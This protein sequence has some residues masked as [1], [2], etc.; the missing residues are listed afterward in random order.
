VLSGWP[1]GG[2]AGEAPTLRRWG[3]HLLARLGQLLGCSWCGNSKRT[4]FI[5]CDSPIDLLEQRADELVGIDHGGSQRQSVRC[6]VHRKKLS[7]RTLQSPCPC[8]LPSP[9]PA[10]A[11]VTRARADKG[12]ETVKAGKGA[13]RT[14]CHRAS[15]AARERSNEWHVLPRSRARLRA[16]AGRSRHPSGVPLQQQPRAG[17]ELTQETRDPQKDR[18]GFRSHQ[19]QAGSLTVSCSERDDERGDGAADRRRGG[20]RGRPPAAR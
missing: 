11:S 15:V 17:G 12:R 1:G 3:A 19:W 4:T 6:E 13:N 5:L 7:P 10:H 8:C 16:P 2:W 9:A 20:G 14:A 18:G